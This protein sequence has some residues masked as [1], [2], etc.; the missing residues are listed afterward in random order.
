MAETEQQMEIR[1]RLEDKLRSGQTQKQGGLGGL[2]A[3]AE[4]LRREN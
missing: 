3:K 2:K 1:K 4:Q